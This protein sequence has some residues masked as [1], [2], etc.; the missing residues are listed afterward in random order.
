M[1]GNDWDERVRA[2]L[3]ATRFEAGRTALI[4]PWL[5]LPNHGDEIS[6]ARYNHDTWPSG[7]VCSLAHLAS[8]SNRDGTNNTAKRKTINR[9]PGMKEM[10]YRGNFN[11][12]PVASTHTVIFKPQKNKNNQLETR[13]V[14]NRGQSRV[15]SKRVA[16]F[17]RPH[18][19]KQESVDSKLKRNILCLPSLSPPILRGFRN[20]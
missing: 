7:R 16:H 20:W 12:P 9:G 2:V 10:R 15:S 17:R 5:I 4:E 6:Q 13:A 8:G 3:A 14:G 19:H 11:L 18:F 1:K